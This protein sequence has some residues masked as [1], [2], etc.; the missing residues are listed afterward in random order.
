MQESSL[1]LVRKLF[2]KYKEKEESGSTEHIKQF[3]QLNEN[4]VEM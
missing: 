3:N 1:N 2:K 4:V